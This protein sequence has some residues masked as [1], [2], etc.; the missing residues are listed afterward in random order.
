M[1]A[2]T[3]TKAPTAP[4]KP[5]FIVVEYNLHYRTN[6]GEE[7]VFNLDVPSGVMEKV[8]GGDQGEAEMFSSILQGM[9]DEHTLD[10]WRKLGFLSEGFPVVMR[11][12]EEF[13]KLTEA[14]V[15]ESQRSSV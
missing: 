11:F 7:I 6:A 8:A 4:E 2:R 13:A 10:Q 14:S 12:F 5:R 1:A 15:G 9:G 3:T